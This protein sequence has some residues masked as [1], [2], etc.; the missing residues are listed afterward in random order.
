MAQEMEIL[1]I[2]YL[3]L[4]YKRQLID[5]I[6]KPPS[7]VK[8]VFKLCEMIITYMKVTQ[9]ILKTM[10]ILLDPIYL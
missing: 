6:D 1:I 7:L 3:S 2:G 8:T 4:V 10:N 5:P 9:Y